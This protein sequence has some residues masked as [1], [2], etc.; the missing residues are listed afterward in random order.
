MVDSEAMEGSA[1]KPARTAARLER[2]LTRAS[3]TLVRAT[4]AH[5]L[6]R[7]ARPA[8]PRDERPRRFSTPRPISTPPTRAIRRGACSRLPGGQTASSGAPVGTVTI[9]G[10]RHFG[11]TH[12]LGYT[13]DGQGGQAVRARFRVGPR[14]PGYQDLADGRRWHLFFFAW[15]FIAC[16]LVVPHR[17]RSPQRPAASWCCGPA[18]CRSCGRC[19]RHYLAPA[20][21]AAGARQIQSAAR[22]WFTP[23]SSSCSRRLIVLSGLALLAGRRRPLRAC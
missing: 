5:A 15:I 20:A 22:S 2:P 1:A 6:D 12:V 10:H 18:I 23:W 9:F 19:K 17:R 14:C 3:G 7:G 8:G 21:G 11:P 4:R 16:G 13:D